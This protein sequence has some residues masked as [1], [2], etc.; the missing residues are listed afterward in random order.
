M[1]IPWFWIQTSIAEIL[2][3]PS[4]TRE[5]YWE[6]AWIIPVD[7]SQVVIHKLGLFQH[8]QL[9]G[10]LGPLPGILV[11]LAVR[12]VRIVSL[13]ILHDA[14]VEIF[15]GSDLRFHSLRRWHSGPE[16]W[17]SSEGWIGNGF[18]WQK[19]CTQAHCQPCFAQ[20]CSETCM[21]TISLIYRESQTV[22]PIW[23][24]QESR[25][26]PH[27]HIPNPGDPCG[28][29]CREPNISWSPLVKVVENLLI[30][31]SNM[32]TYKVDYIWGGKRVTVQGLQWEEMLLGGRE[33]YRV[34]RGGLSV[35]VHVYLI[36][37]QKTEGNYWVKTWTDIL[38]YILHPGE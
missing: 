9:L 15:M 18:G 12:K 21:D 16:N 33:C 24:K 26:T 31:E 6:W 20:V 19:T 30:S 7:I 34:N 13:M 23:H 35:P 38:V 14:C 2:G 25:V 10:W 8:W 32:G 37:N 5:S 4:K 22:F 3:E 1:T 29:C 27:Q 11:S 36:G 28:V 17:L